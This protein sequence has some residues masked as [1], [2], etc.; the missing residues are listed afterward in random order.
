MSTQPAVTV[1]RPLDEVRELWR[2]TEHPFI[3]GAG[4]SVVFRDA[5]GDRGTE[6]HVQIGSGG[7]LLDAVQVLVGNGV[8]PKVKVKDELRRFKQLAETGEIPRSDSTPEG[9]LAERKLKQRPA[10]PLADSELAEAGVR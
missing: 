3:D 2:R 1:N 9:E 5:P 6:I 10:Q 4:G 7:N 8:L